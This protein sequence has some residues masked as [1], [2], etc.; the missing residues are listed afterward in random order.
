MPDDTARAE[1]SA[2][3]PVE[4]G[5]HFRAL[6]ENASD[7]LSVA[8]GEGRYSYVSPSHQRVLGYA[9]E[10]L[11]GRVALDL[12]HPEDAQLLVDHVLEGAG[13][14]LAQERVRFRFRHRDGSWRMLDAI[15]RNALE[16]PNVRG[17]IVNA[18]DITESVR[19]EEERRLNEDRFRRA[20][21][22]APIGMGIVGLDGAFLRVNG[23]YCELVGYSE[24]ELLALDFQ[25]ITH[26][27]DLETDLQHVRDL[28]AGKR[29]SY[30]MEKRYV[31]KDGELVTVLL[32]VSLIC[33]A[34]GRPLHFIAQVL[35]ITERKRM[36][37]ALLTAKEA[38]EEASR[39]KG[40]FL[41]NMS[42]EI[43]TPMNGVLGMTELALGTELDAEQREYVG[44]A[45]E[46]A[47]ALLRVIDDILDFSKIEAGKMALESIDFDLRETLAGT[48]SLFQLASQ[49]KGVRLAA[50][51]DAAVPPFLRGDPGRLRQILANL[52]GNAVKFTANGEV[53]VHVES[54]RT[55][56]EGLWLHFA[57]RDTGI[58]IGV[59]QQQHIFEAFAQADLSMRRR[60]G[61]T[62]LG[63]TISDGLVR[64]MGGRVWVESEPGQGSTFHFIARFDAAALAAPADAPVVAPPAELRSLDILLAEDNAVNQKLAIRLL[65]RRGHRVTLATDGL[66]AVAAARSGRFD[67]ILMD[68]QMPHMDGMEA[69]AT[70]RDAERAHGV[71]VPIVAMTA[72]AMKGDAERCL[73]AGMDGY[74]AKPIDA[75]QLFATIDTVTAS[76]RQKRVA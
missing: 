26:A 56:V 39:A 42:H 6:L 47:R 64:M 44:L 12:I 36:E 15:G 10:E 31:R 32:H 51:I 21:S 20:F 7:L 40:E 72:H 66:Q 70:I 50:T 52:V 43:R 60:F 46:S 61:G 4:M 11:L 25:A 14:T 63:L 5:E 59:E 2:Q 8:D 33:D 54:I 67:V 13:A 28:L 75:R 38:A 17:V 30:Q 1:G 48:T 55:G 49:S 34:H 41:A 73:E 35:D 29:R 58:G 3:S 37:A 69:T 18:R 9:P 76:S 45:H 71:H 27:D 22:H 74:V 24:E 57:V 23:A 16:D 68:V 53:A 65:E 62:G 19:I